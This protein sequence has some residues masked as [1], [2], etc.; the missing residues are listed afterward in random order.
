MSVPLAILSL[1]LLLP[2]RISAI[3][4]DADPILVVQLTTANAALDRNELL[5]SENQWV[6]DHCQ[7]PHYSWQPGSVTSA[8]KATFPAMWGMGLTISMLNLGP[9]AILPPH[10]HPR[11]NNAVVAVAGNTT[12]YMIQEN[13]AGVVQTTL[14]PGK[15]TIFPMGSIHTMVNNSMSESRVYVISSSHIFR[16]PKADPCEDCEPA[17]LVSAL[18]SD[19]PGILNI[20]N[21]LWNLPF[22]FLEVVLGESASSYNTSARAIPPI[23]TGSNFGFPEC[24]ARCNI[25]ASSNT[26]V[27]SNMTGSWPTVVR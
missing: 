14:T 10:L 17:Q 19:D 8:N 15:M 12:T 3:D 1:L 9:C 21:A 26:T 23:G 27:S 18:S 22:E 7:N 4:Q 2:I 5:S 20:A 25:T 16:G 24:I 11:G 13:G 6:Y